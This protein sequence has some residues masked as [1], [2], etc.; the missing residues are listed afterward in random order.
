MALMNEVG[1][2]GLTIDG[3][4]ARASVGRPTIY[5]RWPSKQALVVAALLDTPRIQVPDVDTGS[6]RSD[7]L[8]VLQHQVALMNKPENRRVTAGLVADLAAD[9][10]LGEKYVSEYL[11]PRRAV[12]LRLFERGIDRGELAPDANLAL[13]YEMLLGPLFMRS[14]IWGRQL[15]RDTAAELVEVVLRAFAPR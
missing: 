9:P 12:V 15:G 5:R 8:K 10:E 2:A 11:V 14:V 13:A 4:A 6:L 3:V 1:Y 7:L